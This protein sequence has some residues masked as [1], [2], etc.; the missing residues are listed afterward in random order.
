M[1]HRLTSLLIKS[2]PNVDESFMGYITRLTEW[3]GY[4]SP[5]WIMQLAGFD[6]S[7]LSHLCSFE[8]RSSK[9]L[10]SL[11]HLTG[12]NLSEL[13]QLTYQPAN[14]WP[15]DYYLFFG[16]PVHRYYIRPSH[17]K[18]CPECLREAAY[19]RRAW[20]LTLITVC[21]IHKCILIDV[22]PKCERRITWARKSVTKCRCDFDWRQAPTI[23]VQGHELNLARIIYRLC[24]LPY[25]EDT[26]CLSYQNPSLKLNL[27]DFMFAVVFIAGQI[28]GLSIRGNHLLPK[29]RNKEIHK[30]L[31]GAYYV[32]EDWPNNFYQ[33]LNWW[34]AQ[35]RNRSPT[36]LRL[37]SVLYRDFGKLY[38]GFYKT[39]LGGH[40][41]FIRDAFID[42]LIE[43]WEGCE[44]PPFTRKKS[45]KQTPTVKYISKSDAKLILD[46]DEL[47]IA[48]LFELGSLRTTVR[49]KGMKRL[50]FVDVLDVA[51]LM[52]EPSRL[53]IH[54]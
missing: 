29:A 53:D 27:H 9:A 12:T 14:N 5:S 44:I 35:Q 33:F 40:Y 41:D 50:I 28:L 18:I 3:N 49:S 37:K 48:Q 47:L 8:P 54:H 36:L 32:F 2:K 7:L 1:K 42:F 51:K 23:S 30:L 15:G 19:C 24:D 22:C 13:A 39:L 4:D 25:N 34:R 6:Y 38:I 43:G 10:N 21:P 31:T 45:I 17:F 11:T 20:E 26:P 52:R 46:I 16:S